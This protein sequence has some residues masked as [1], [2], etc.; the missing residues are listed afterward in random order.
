MQ[1]QKPV[2]MYTL[3]TCSHCAA[4][5]RFLDESGVDYDF[6]DVDLLGSL[7]KA[8][9]LEEMKKYNPGCTFPT[10]VIG[11]RVIIGNRQDEIKEAL[12]L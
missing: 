12:G 10:L 6:T 9:A 3:S 1:K 8:A 2:K 11:D 4:A 7:E 5:K